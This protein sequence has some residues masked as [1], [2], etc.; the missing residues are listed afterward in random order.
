MV[1][2]LSNSQIT[3]IL[4]SLQIFDVDKAC[5]YSSDQLL[6]KKIHFAKF[7]VSAV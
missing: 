3:I 5:F 1:Q 7:Y 4:R 6:S 2:V